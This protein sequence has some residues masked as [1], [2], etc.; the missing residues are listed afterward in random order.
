L[1]GFLFDPDDG[2]S[3]FRRNVGT[4]LLK[5]TTLHPIRH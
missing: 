1:L 5:Y 2:S 4:L 3:T